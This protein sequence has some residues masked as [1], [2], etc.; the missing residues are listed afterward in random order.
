[1]GKSAA[2][3]APSAAAINFA[4]TAA[5]R[6]GSFE[7][8]PAQRRL[9]ADGGRA[10]A[11]GARAFDVLLVLV[12][13][14]GQLVPKSQLLELVWPGVVVEENNLQVQVSALRRILGQQAIATIPGR[15]YRFTLSLADTKADGSP[16]PDVPK[17]N[18]P[19]PLTS[20]VGHES[21]LTQY[22]QMLEQT[23]LLTLTGIG[24]CGKTR[25]AIKLA[26]MI[27]PSFQDGVCFVDLASVAEPERVSLAVATT[28]QIGE[29]ADKA[30]EETL[31]RHLAPRQLL[32]VLDNCEHLIGACA[33][34]VELLLKA[35]PGMRA[36][37]TS[38]E[39]LGVAG[40]L[41]V[42]VRSLSSPPAGS[43]IAVETVAQF[44]AVRLFV[45]RARHVAPEFM[46]NATNAP[47]IMEICRRLDG[48]P[49]AL[50]LAAAR[51][52]LLSP[53]QI[54]AKLHD[55]F[56]LLT[57]SSRAM[58]RH[59]TL[60][61]TLQ[62]SYEQLVPDEQEWLQRLSVFAGGWTLDA[63]AAVA[64]EGCDELAA[65]ERLER[66]VDKSL[67]LVDRTRDEPRYSMLETVRQYAH[68]RLTSD[69]SIAL[70]ERH[71][72]HF[73]ALAKIASEDLHTR[74]LKRSLDKIDVE[75]PNLMAAHEWCASAQNGASQGLELVILL[76][77]YWINCGL[78]ALGQQVYDEALGRK[79]I[80]PRSILRAKTLFSNGQHNFFRGR[81]T[82]VLPLTE[83]AL[84]IAREH[85]DAELTLACLEL[86]VLALVLLGNSARAIQCASEQLA[87]AK[88]IGVPRLIGFALTSM[89]EVRR[90]QGDFDAAAEAYE[91]ALPLLGDEDRVNRAF[92]LRDI[93]RVAIARGA[94]DRAREALAQS[95]RMGME[96]GGRYSQQRDLEAASLLVAASG[97]WK[98]AARL[99]GAANSAADAMG[100]VRNAQDDRV[101]A[102]LRE[103]PR[104]MLGAD[105]YTREHEAGCRL[106]VE[107]ALAE[108]LTWLDESAEC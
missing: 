68:E 54:R 44:E 93:A 38:R 20:F 47:A 10:V 50:E 67:V 32:L 39:G 2:I 29:E 23:R 101:S 34:L 91:Q 24:G 46:L 66:L 16:A 59:Q 106:S 99:Q 63:A 104:E 31:T 30:I 4:V 87:I 105:V 45:D 83:E 96:V 94:L 71:F 98:R 48:I 22:A 8:Q 76:R 5:Y 92:A 78:F 88:K 77:L 51:L 75:L 64:G 6:F 58:S 81:L 18:L 103:K 42:S 36:L 26:E 55:R 37:A 9:L 100:G 52:R 65:L 56:R 33:A 69:E 61:A 35:A 62:W 53:E 108:V 57:S 90:A 41:T 102:A 82:E 3:A 17:H 73:L 49:L 80:G 7:L 74:N 79:G 19:Q 28:L 86:L 85:G 43:A 84:S 107:D 12:E 25:L 1:L 72:A 21:D 70:R 40:E 60:L 14:A 89:G 15:G 11:L 27:L 13:H 95:I 97:D